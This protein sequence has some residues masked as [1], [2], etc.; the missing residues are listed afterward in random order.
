MLLVKDE[1]A[2]PTGFDMWLPLLYQYGLLFLIHKQCFD[3]PTLRLLRTG[4][5]HLYFLLKLDI[6]IVAVHPLQHFQ[7]RTVYLPILRQ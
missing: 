5:Q 1:L 3:E 4:Q 7:R 2:S 6:H